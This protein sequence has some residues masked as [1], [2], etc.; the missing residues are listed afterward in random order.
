MEVEPRSLTF[1]LAYSILGR[2]FPIEI[3][4]LKEVNVECL[5]WLLSLALSVLA[6]AFFVMKAQ[7]FHGGKSG[8]A[9]VLLFATVIWGLFSLIMSVIS[10]VQAGVIIV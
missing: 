9:I 4:P 1:C 2:F 5:L 3:N 10:L 8:L 7:G 6:A